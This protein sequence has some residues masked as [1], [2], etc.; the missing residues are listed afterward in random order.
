[1]TTATLTIDLTALAAN[2]TALNRLSTSEAGA[3]VKAD[4]YGLGIARVAPVL[5]AAGARTLPP[6]GTPSDRGG[7]RICCSE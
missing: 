7:T 4:A 6:D 5:A 1:M 3:V 2:W